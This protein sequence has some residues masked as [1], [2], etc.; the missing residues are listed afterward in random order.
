LRGKNLMPSVDPTDVEWLTASAAD[1]QRS[2]VQRIQGA[3][4][5]KIC[6]ER[7]D[8][9]DP[10]ALVQANMD[11]VHWATQTA[12]L[13]PGEFPQQSL[14]SYYVEFYREQV[15]Q[16]GHRQFVR[17]GCMT[18][19]LVGCCVRGMAAMGATHRLA[20]FEQLLEFLA[21]T[22][23][24]RIDADLAGLLPQAESVLACLDRRFH[25]LQDNH[26]LTAL[27]A[28]WL[29][30]LP[31]WLPLSI[32]VLREAREQATEVNPLLWVR[33]REARRKHQAPEEVDAAYRVIKASCQAAGRTLL[34]LRT[35][36]PLS[37][38]RISAA[39]PD[40]R[41]CCWW[42]LTD[43]GVYHAFLYQEPG[44]FGSKF[45]VAL[46][47]KDASRPAAVTAVSRSEY[48]EIVA[49]AFVKQAATQH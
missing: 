46:W 42:V 30:R 7:S 34:R 16:G 12:F 20:I 3:L 21:T 27:N 33:A 43:A 32:E 35:S 1:D 4:L 15:S 29:L 26:D 48:E 14:W 8:A 38:R 49:R 47:F 11:F 10:R 41:T 31:C 9:Y 23:Q 22:D 25:D 17:N 40:R 44:L 19:L 18:P 37:M 45:R 24:S 36:A 13:V 2:P 6:V 28:A 5:D 39:A